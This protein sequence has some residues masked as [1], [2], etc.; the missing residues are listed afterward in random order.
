MTIPVPETCLREGETAPSIDALAAV[1]LNANGKETLPARFRALFMLRGAPLGS[2]QDKAV[3]VIG[4]AF[5]DRSAL[6]K[7]ELAYV[8]GQMRSTSAIP[9]L[10]SVLRDLGQDAMVRHEAAEALGAIG[11]PSALPV[12]DEFLA[13]PE[14]A[15]R[16]TCEIAVS[17]I[18]EGRRGGCCGSDE[19]SC[20]SS[21]DECGGEIVFG[22][23][24]PAPALRSRLNVSDLQTRL[25][26]TSS[27]LYDRYKAMFSLRNRATEEAVLAL[28]TGFADDSALFRH[29]I[30]YVLGQLQHPASVPALAA[31]LCNKAE[32]A[33]VRHECA[34]ALGSVATEECLSILRAYEN[35]AAEEAVVRESCIVARDMYEY[36]HST[37]LNM[38]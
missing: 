9:V 3:E 32:V 18:S 11:C 15:V 27:P 36:E 31:V 21:E 10:S 28:C 8:L 35:D 13:D 1:L 17:L 7:H 2:E 14:R 23:V 26:D 37:E 34:E 24:D 4:R 30:A 29:E 19:R 25:M 16:E 22:S 12:L 38:L 6:L 5:C 20:C 33:M